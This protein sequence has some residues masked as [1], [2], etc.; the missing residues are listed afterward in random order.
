MAQ[1][2]HGKIAEKVAS[3]KVYHETT[4]IKTESKWEVP[5]LTGKYY[6]GT[7]FVLIQSTCGKIY[8]GV[9]HCIA[10]D[11]FNPER[12]EEIATGRAEKALYA[13]LI[14][15]RRL[16]EYSCFLRDGRGLRGFMI[17]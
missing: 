5:D 9:A 14:E 16:C 2:F 12:G 13:H 11:G 4:T 3:A 8:M 17:E 15:D 10:I 7:T 6:T 1:D